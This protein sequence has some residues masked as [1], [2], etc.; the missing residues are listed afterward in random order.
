MQI[1]FQYFI[2]LPKLEDF[3]FQLGEIK[4]CLDFF[5][6]DNRLTTPPAGGPRPAYGSRKTETSYYLSTDLPFDAPNI[7]GLLRVDG[8]YVLL[9]D[10]V[11]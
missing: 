10:L 8:Y 6:H 7:S 4:F 2:F 9:K 5:E 11:H 1:L 3:V